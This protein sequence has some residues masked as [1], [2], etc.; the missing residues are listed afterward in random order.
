V[1]PERLSEAIA[2]LEDRSSRTDIQK[3]LAALHHGQPLQR[4]V[5]KRLRKLHVLP[6][7]TILA[8]IS[9][10]E[11]VFAV[12][13]QGRFLVNATLRELELRLN[14]ESFV[15]IHKQTIVNLT[16]IAELEPIVKGGAVVRLAN[17][18]TLEISRRYA[19]GFRQRLGW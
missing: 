8:F 12:T 9:E 1:E 4:I 3:L 16:K 2:R 17:G 13:A 19:A 14:R 11:L 15:R 18:E 7:E 10:Q 6:V 5:G